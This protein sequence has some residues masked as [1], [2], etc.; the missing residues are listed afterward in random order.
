MQF[1]SFTTVTW[2]KTYLASVTEQFNI[3]YHYSIIANVIKY[4]RNVA[5]CNWPSATLSSDICLA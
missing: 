1:N 4:L 5:I 2:M 3:W